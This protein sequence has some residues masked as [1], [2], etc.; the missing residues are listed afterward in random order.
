MENQII[1]L[2]AT[3]LLLTL[4]GCKWRDDFRERQQPQYF[5]PTGRPTLNH[6]SIDYVG[7]DTHLEEDVEKSTPLPS[8]D[9]LS[10]IP[11]VPE[12]PAGI[13]PR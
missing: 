13:Q 11:E 1:I 12:Y 6:D 2:M 4:Q 3:L 10:P 5:E 9:R 7:D 8:I